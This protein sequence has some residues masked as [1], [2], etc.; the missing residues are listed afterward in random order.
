[1]KFVLPNESVVDMTDCQYTDA[2]WIGNVKEKYRNKY[3]TFCSETLVVQMFLDS[4]F[5][6]ENDLDYPDNLV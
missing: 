2:V 6:F 1:M 5:S 4:E 3:V